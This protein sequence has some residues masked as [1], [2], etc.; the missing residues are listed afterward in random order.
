MDCQAD[1][2]AGICDNTSGG[3]KYDCVYNQTLNSSSCVIASGGFYP[4][5]TS[6]NNACGGSGSVFDWY[7]TE[8]VIANICIG[9]TVGGAVPA[10]AVT[11]IP[12]ATYADCQATCVSNVEK[13]FCACNLTLEGVLVPLSPGQFGG[14]YCVNWSSA[15][16]SM[17][18]YSFATMIDCELNCL[19]WDC[20]ENTGGCSQYNAENY[21]V[22]QYCHGGA[23]ILGGGTEIFTSNLTIDIPGC[24]DQCELPST[25]MCIG[26]QCTFL[27]LSDTTCVNPTHASMGG[28]CIDFD[29][30]V[31]WNGASCNDIGIATCQAP[32]GTQCGQGCK[33]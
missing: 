6:C 16:S 27:D 13:F 18:A 23:D 29:T 2:T 28:T 24:G 32:L 12:H 10:N 9:V 17:D 7:C 3:L 14:Q 25:H 33:P 4:D 1:V 19:S 5:L 26:G 31:A 22:G 21:P 15:P 11:G 30:A 8:E 20:D